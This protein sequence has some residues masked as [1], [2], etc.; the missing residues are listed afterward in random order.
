MT[1]AFLEHQASSEVV[2]H[3]MVDCTLMEEVIANL[4][5]YHLIF[6]SIIRLHTHLLEATKISDGTQHSH[7]PLRFC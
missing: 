7:G 4:G 6:D 3:Q 1:L 5:T 2:I